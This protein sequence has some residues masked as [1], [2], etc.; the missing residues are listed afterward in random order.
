MRITVQAWQLVDPKSEPPLKTQTGDLFDKLIEPAGM[1][2]VA[3]PPG[4]QL[5]PAARG[6]GSALLTNNGLDLPRS[7]K[8]VLMI[9]LV[10]SVRLMALDESG[11]VSRWHQFA[12]NAQ[13]VV[14]PQHQGR[15]VKSLGD[16]LLAE[17]GDCRHAVEAAFALH[18]SLQKIQADAGLA[19]TMKMRAGVHSA[20]RL[21]GQCRHLWRRSEPGG[22]F[23]NIGHP[24]GDGGLRPGV[25][26]NGSNHGCAD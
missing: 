21:D 15:L 13:S 9:D 23:G 18:S 25:C 24:G 2:M 7:E 17:F 19:Q 11:T 22:A 6:I 5:E 16:G 3:V 10:E 26:A 8:V 14:L 1:V 12:S 4:V 20:P